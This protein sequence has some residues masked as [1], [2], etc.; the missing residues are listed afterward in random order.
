MD[1]PKKDLQYVN[2]IESALQSLTSADWEA[3]DLAAFNFAQNV[4]LDP[5]W[6][7]KE[8]LGRIMN[9][10]R[11]W[12]PKNPTPFRNF[13]CGVMKSIRNEVC[14]N[15]PGAIDCHYMQLETYPKPPEEQLEQKEREGWAKQVVESTLDHFSD[16]E[17]VLAIIIGKSEDLTGEEIRTQEQMTRKQYDAALR[18]LSRYRNEKFPMGATNE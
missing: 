7:L 10:Q 8:S 9:G 11:K 5:S 2:E 18:R 1:D 4:A 14:K 3:I 6:L 13:F 15:L 12:P 17:H 16:D